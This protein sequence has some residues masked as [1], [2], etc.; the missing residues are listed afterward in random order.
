M[1][2]SEE[3]GIFTAMAARDE[4]YASYLAPRIDE[5]A[6]WSTSSPTSTSP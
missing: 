5:H 2:A 6:S 3:A 1:T 4:E